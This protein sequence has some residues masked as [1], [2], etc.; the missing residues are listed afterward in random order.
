MPLLTKQRIKVCVTSC[1][2]EQNNVL[3][4]HL[5]PYTTPHTYPYTHAHSQPHVNITSSA[6]IAIYTYFLYLSVSLNTA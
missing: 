3:Y 6:S 5:K 1:R 2:H 4:E